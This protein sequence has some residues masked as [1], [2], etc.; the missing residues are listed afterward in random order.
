MLLLESVLGV[1]EGCWWSM[2]RVQSVLEYPSFHQFAQIWTGAHSVELLG[3]QPTH[4]WLVRSTI[5]TACVHNF[6]KVGCIELKSKFSV[7]NC[8]IVPEHFSSQAVWLLL[9]GYAQVIM[10]VSEVLN[11]GSKSTLVQISRGKRLRYLHE[12]CDS[13]GSDSI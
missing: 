2:Q 11:I 10:H 12:L 9:C 13:C 3:V 8:F 7:V 1:S 6:V 5:S 4:K